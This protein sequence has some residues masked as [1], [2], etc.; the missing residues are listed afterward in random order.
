MTTQPAADAQAPKLDPMTRWLPIIPALILTLIVG[1]YAHR[2][3]TLDQCAWSGVGFGMF[4]RV[5]GYHTRF[6]RITATS[7]DGTT[8]RLDLPPEAEQARLEAATVPT[9]AKLDALAAIILARA[10]ADVRSVEVKL[11]RLRYEPTTRTLH[12]ETMRTAQ[13]ARP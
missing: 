4:A 2:M 9:A 8:R 1:L 6:V 10:P 5:D 12:A 11:M 3:Y 13:D 7:T